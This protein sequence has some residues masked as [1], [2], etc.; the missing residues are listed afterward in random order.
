MTRT[1]LIVGFLNGA[2]A[3]AYLVAGVY[4]LRF[5]RKTR[6]RLFLSFSAAFALLA[7][8]LAI[9]VT[10]GVEDER[11]GYSYVLRVLGFLLILYAILR[12]NVGGR[13]PAR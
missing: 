9:V 11:T 12:K 3:M 7:T 10:L 4:F 1:D 8:N 13:R 6:D 2:M 5:W